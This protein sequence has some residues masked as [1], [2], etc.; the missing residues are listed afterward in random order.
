MM[1]K[2]NSRL[3]VFL[4]LF[5]LICGIASAQI[6][7]TGSLRGS[8]LDRDGAPLPGAQVTIKSPSLIT[9]SMT[10]ITNER[11]FYRFPALP[12][13]LYTVTFR[14]DGFSALIREGI[15]I[16]AGIVTT[17]DANLD[18]DVIKE[19]VLVIGQAPTVDRVQAGLS[20]I[21]SKELIEDVPASRDLVNVLEMVPGVV[22]RATHGSAQRD[23]AYNLDG[24]NINDP[25]LGTLNVGLSMDIMEEVSVQTGGL[26]A[27]YGSVRGSVINVITK[28]GGN[29]FSGSGL[30]YFRN[31]SL[32]SDNTKGTPFEGQESGFDY[33]VDG[34]FNLGGPIIKNKIWFFG[35]LTYYASD[36]FVLGYPWEKQPV[37]TPVDLSKP[38]I[39]GKLTFQLKPQHTLVLS[40]NHSNE[41]SDHDGAS[42]QRSEDATRNQSIPT[43]TIN[44]Q[45]TSFFGKNFIVETKAAF[46]DYTQKML[47]KTGL[48]RLYETSTRLYSQG[49]GY[50][51]IHTKKRWQFV[52]NGTYFIDD[53]WGNHELKAGAE[54]EYSW[55]KRDRS[56][57]RDPRINLGPNI[58]LTNGIPSYVEHQESYIRRDKKLLLGGFIQDKWTI[59]K[60][61]NLNIG[62]RFDHQEGI[63]PKQGEERDP[64]T[65]N[66]ITYYPVVAETFK[67]IIWN[68]LAPRF[69]LTYDIS[70]NGKTIVKASLGRYYMANVMQWFVTV[71]PNSD[72]QWRQRL[73]ADWT[74]RGDPYNVSGGS[75]ASIDPNIKSPYLDELTIGIERELITDLSLGF[76]Y[77][78]KWDRNLVE[79][80]F[81]HR[82]DYEALMERGELIWT[83]F[84]PVTVVDPY[85][86]QTVTFYE[87]TDL[88]A[89]GDSVVTNPPGAQRDYDGFEIDLTKRYSHGWQLNASYVWAYSRGLI[90]TSTVD[91]WSGRAYF[92]NPNYHINRYGRFPEE[93]RH[94]FKV[95][96]VYH[97]PWGINFGSYFRFLSGKRYA[98]SIT[99]SHL[100][101]DLAQGSVTILA[102]ERGTRACPD[103]YM[104]DL[105]LDKSFQ[106]GKVGQIELM[107]DIFNAFNINTPTS[108][109]EVSSSPSLV[110]EQATAIYDPR[111]IR[112]GAR[113]KF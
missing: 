38:F 17:L 105:R 88:T 29:E 92:N 35:N 98:R 15:K 33:E 100:G 75:V 89:P 21:V 80:V 68:T 49:Y 101:L 26:Q 59:N 1:L 94:Q 95:Q 10:Q 74:L 46:V 5:F 3:P 73:N 63:I 14:L 85:D 6:T 82:L 104:L 91:D 19:E 52:M 41:R 87:Q 97:G 108:V 64:V 53:F 12:P 71:N 84:S 39:Y 43:H 103:L 69:G 48:P 60:R 44:F 102:E 55:D 31:K 16:S 34:G 106:L 9:P 66:G 7:L 111:I 56:Y 110:F 54:V 93:R 13:G 113:F 22:G 112:F 76:R 58:N 32:Q 18:M 24:V 20:H 83:I 90:D 61:L 11:G 109:Q 72:L 62:L 4:L 65:L 51:E 45:L 81:I 25:V 78:R 50:D 8:V 42:W 28:S 96:A 67:P 30:L 23:N 36:S 99:S 79:D 37:N 40:Y 70:G 77:I 57:H 86:G 2:E 107:I 47:S 27:E